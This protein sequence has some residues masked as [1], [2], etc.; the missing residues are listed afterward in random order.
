M[1]L[2]IWLH[3]IF[4]LPWRGVR[5]MLGVARIIFATLG[6]LQRG[7][8]APVTLGTA[9][10]RLGLADLFSIKAL[11]PGCH[12]M[13]VNDPVR[14]PLCS[15][16]QIP[17]FKNSQPFDPSPIPD[18]FPSECRQRQ[19][20]N[21]TVPVLQAPYM[22]LSDIL[23]AFINSTL[24]MEDDLDRWRQTESLP[25]QMGRIQDGQI[26]Q[27]LAGPDGQPFFDNSPER[28]Q[29]HELRIGITIG[30]D[31]QAASCA[32][33]NTRRLTDTLRRF[34][35]SRSAFS[36]SHSTGVLSVSIANLDTNLRYVTYCQT[37][38]LAY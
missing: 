13:H 30:F 1:L 7:D 33:P 28:P 2:G 35:F 5:V 27:T 31:G 4:G 6:L 25:N 34:S 19:H 17:L 12:R 26:W 18:I 14:C 16:C 29:P 24:T 10:S 8:D 3:N 37:I 23:P 32:L 9:Y 36:G 11:C 21:N 15:T 22:L 38:P 20:D